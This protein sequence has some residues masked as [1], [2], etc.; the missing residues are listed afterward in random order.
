[1]T[2]VHVYPVADLIDH[3]TEG[4]DCPCGPTTEAVPADDGSMGWLVTHHSL[5][6]RER[7]ET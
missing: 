2:T 7:T 4:D 6:G 3:E 5:D 1:V